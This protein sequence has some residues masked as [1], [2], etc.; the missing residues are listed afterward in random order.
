MFQ[1]NNF[2]EIKKYNIKYI[3]NLDMSKHGTI[4]QP[5]TNVDEM[6]D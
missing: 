3:Q 2:E 1:T 6:L 5:D 4:N